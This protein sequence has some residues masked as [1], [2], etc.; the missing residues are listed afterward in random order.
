MYYTSEENVQILIALLKKH[1]VSKIIASPGTMNISFV[2]SVQTDNYFTIY[3]A[4]D[5]RSAAYM[6]CG[7]AKEC[8]EPVVITCT[9]ATASRNYIPGLTE[10]FYSK[11]PIISVTFSQPFAY[12]GQNRPQVMDRR[13]QLN[14]MC[15]KYD[16]STRTIFRKL[17][18]IEKRYCKIIKEK[19]SE[20]E[21]C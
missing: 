7:L 10:A 21:I 15:I 17:E 4:P 5:E 2:G 13:T 18:S 3:S 19:E 12:I 8:N 16:I 14:D 11:I 6:A 1:N 20:K 9:G